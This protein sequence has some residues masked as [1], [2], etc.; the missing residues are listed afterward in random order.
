MVG[1]VGCIYIIFMDIS[2]ELQIESKGH[3]KGLDF[4]QFTQIQ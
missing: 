2:K 3:R 1:I 4:W